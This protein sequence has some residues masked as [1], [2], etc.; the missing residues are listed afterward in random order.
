MTYPT[1][2]TR[3]AF[4]FYRRCERFAKR[5]ARQQAWGDPNAFKWQ[6]RAHID[7]ARYAVIIHDMTG[8][9]V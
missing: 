3:E 6:V 5:W 9:W 2:T 8:R 4:Y 7:A 1:I